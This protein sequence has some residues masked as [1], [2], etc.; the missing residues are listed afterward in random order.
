[1]TKVT[2]SGDWDKNNKKSPIGEP[3]VIT[4]NS[5]LKDFSNT[6]HKNLYFLYVDQKGQSVFTSG[7]ITTVPFE[8]P[9]LSCYL[10]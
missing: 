9:K 8:V 10:V 6:I 4:F 5:L 2:F 3:L 7:T 1:M